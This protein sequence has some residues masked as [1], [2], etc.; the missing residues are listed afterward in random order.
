LPLAADLI[1]NA[2]DKNN[3]LASAGNVHLF[4]R[5]HYVD[6]ATG[7]YGIESLIVSILKSHNAVFPANIG[8]NPTFRSVAI[9]I[10]MF[11]SDVISE[12]RET[13]GSD[14]YPDQTI[15][16]FLSVFMGSKGNNRVGKIALKSTEDKDRPCC[17]PR[18]KYFLVEK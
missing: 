15:Q 9:S 12:V 10:S 18:T 11:A 1:G 8:D 4:V 16:S 2:Q 6:V 5:D 14:R 7:T 13:F 17:K 3:I